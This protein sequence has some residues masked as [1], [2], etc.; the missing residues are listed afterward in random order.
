VHDPVEAN[1]WWWYGPDWVYRPV[2]GPAHQ[3]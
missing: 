2:A 1:D 3:P